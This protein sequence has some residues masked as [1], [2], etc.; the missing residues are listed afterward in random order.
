MTLID[1]FKEFHRNATQQ[2]Y[3]PSSRVLYMTLLGE[4]NS[5]RW[6]DSLVLSTR[7][8]AQLTGL[9]TTSVHRAKQF[10]TSK[11]IIKCRPFKNKTSF[12]LTE[13]SRNTNGTVTE[14]SRNTSENPNIRV[15]EEDV[16]TL[17]NQ[18]IS[19]SRGRTCAFNW[20]VD[21]EERLTALWLENR[22]AGV[23]F[24]LLSYLR[25]I[26]EKHGLLYAEDLIREMAGALKNDR[27]TLN[28]LR[29]AY[30]FKLKGGDNN[31]Q[32]KRAKV[33][34]I[35]EQSYAIPECTGDE[36]WQKYG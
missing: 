35:G 26:V 5:A 14:Q 20:D 28:Y 21:A 16:K 7:D 3:P 1:L 12:S 9:P 15:R 34:A 27:M 36:P 10:L 24:E 8:L 19:Q 13:Q 4:F 2:E 32:R 23:T 31:A 33:V 11:G 29:G 17:D 25:F 22:G 30:N 6:P 18:S